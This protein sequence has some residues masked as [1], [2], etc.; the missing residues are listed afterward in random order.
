MA[1]PQI[2]IRLLPSLKAEFERYANDLGLRASELA[3]LLIV[4]EWRLKRLAKRHKAGNVPKRERQERGSA[5]KLETITAHVSSVD[6][7]EKFDA[8]AESCSLNRN[9]AGAWLLETELSEEWLKRALEIKRP[10]VRSR[11][12]TAN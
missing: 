8:Y 9:H 2:T 7:V 1:V 5:I 4:R 3:K 6:Q 12:G 10:R 11:Q